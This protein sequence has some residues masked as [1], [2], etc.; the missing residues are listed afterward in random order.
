VEQDIVRAIND[1]NVLVFDYHGQP[2]EV[3]P[4]A[5]GRVQPHDKTVLLAWQTG[6][7]SNH[8][9]PPLWAYFRLDDIE[10]LELTDAT[11]FS[12]QPNFKPRFIDLIHSI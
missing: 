1:R 8:G 11:F 2:R 7:S 10:G 9:V 3:N 4:H 6:G 12:A 5:L